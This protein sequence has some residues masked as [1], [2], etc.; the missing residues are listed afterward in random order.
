MNV[1]GHMG[2]LGKE[3]TG[4]GRN[5]AQIFPSLIHFAL[6]GCTRS[7]LMHLYSSDSVG[8][9]TALMLE[10]NAPFR[11]ECFASKHLPLGPFKCCFRLSPESGLHRARPWASF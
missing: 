3:A 6:G 7:K 11:V 5:D 2:G 10:I 9:G 1:W 8:N 4:K